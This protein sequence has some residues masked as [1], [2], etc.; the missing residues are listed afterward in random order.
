MRQRDFGIYAEGRGR[1]ASEAMKR[2]L[3]P[4]RRSAG[5]SPLKIRRTQP[6]DAPAVARIFDGPKVVWGTM[7]LPF[8]S[9]EVWHQ[10]LSRETDATLISLVACVGGDLVGALGLHLNGGQP[11]R[12]HVAEVGM[13]VRDDSQGR[14]VGHALLG[15]ALD[16]ADRWLALR[17]V[18]LTV[19]VDNEPAIRLY[20]KHGFEVEG[21]L[22]E[23][24][25]R[26]G[27]YVDGFLMAR[28]RPT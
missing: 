22:R 28:L 27:K 26:D 10:R 14:G 12:Q 21:T 11:R 19:Y 9:A 20:R 18:Q 5:G 1:L 15:A 23:I 6:A 2:P 4:K 8:A 13:A 7:Q 17:R 3:S 16:L 24:A 25:F